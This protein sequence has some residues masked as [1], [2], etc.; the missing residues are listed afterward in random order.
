[1][2]GLRGRAAAL[3]AR[4]E[5]RP[6]LAALALMLLASLFLASMHFLVRLASDGLHPFEIAFFRNVFGFCVLVPWLMRLGAAAFATRRFPLHAARGVLN[7]GSMLL[8]FLALSLM[9][10]ADATA[11][12]L[13]S[14]L[15]VTVGGILILGEPMRG[16]R[17][18]GLGLGIAGMLA[19]LRPG[20]EEIGPG[21]LAVIASAV[22]V[23]ASRLIAKTL[24][25]TESPTAIVA[26]LTALMIPVTALPAAL[27]WQTPTLSQLPLL[28]G[29]GALGSA[30]HLCLMH[31]YR[32]ADVGL[33]E[34][35][36]FF[37]LVWAALFGFL[38]FAEIPDAGV[39]IGGLLIVAAT[40][41]L[42]RREGGPPIRPPQSLP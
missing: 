22:F 5:S 23:T 19:I 25:R 42:A 6:A 27:V 37:R 36:V 26:W 17:W 35:M 7:G 29:I 11:L 30:G 1:M 38:A 4:A 8:W 10:L 24:T 41:N 21:A 33:V 3:A 14:P 12:S 31:A 9:P 16:R 2:T 40:T 13:A 39:W 28:V 32:L 20:F 34:P 18:A 15:F